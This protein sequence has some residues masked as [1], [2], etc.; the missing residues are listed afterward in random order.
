MGLWNTGITR[1]KTGQLRKEQDIEDLLPALQQFL[2]G[3]SNSYK[4]KCP[5][6]ITYTDNMIYIRCGQCGVHFFIEEKSHYQMMNIFIQELDSY[7]T[8][9]IYTSDVNMLCVLRNT[10]NR[11]ITMFTYSQKLSD[12]FNPTKCEN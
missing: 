2:D 5:F 9:T 3:F 11:N 10:L 6:D 8:H 1:S 4:T 7:L 12:L